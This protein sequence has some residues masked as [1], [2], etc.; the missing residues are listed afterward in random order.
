[1]NRDLLDD[2]VHC[3]FCLDT[4]PTYVLWGEEPDSPRG[5]ILLMDLVEK[6][7]LAMDEAVIRHWDRCLGCMACVTSCPSGV[8]YDRLIEEARAVVGAT[9]RRHRLLFAA[10]PHHR[11]LRPA[12][13][14]IAAYR[15][16]H[17]PR[18]R[19]MPPVSFAG[20]RQRTPPFLPAQGP[21]RLKVAML[22]GCVQRAFFGDV[23]AATAR[24]LSAYGCD[25][26]AP[27]GQGCC[28]ALELHSGQPGAE[29]RRTRLL[30]TLGAVDADVIVVNAAGCGSAL[31]E[32]DHPAAARVRDVHEVLA[33][34]GP[35]AAIRPL[36]MT[37]AY[38]DAC[39]LAHAQ[40]VRA[41]PRAVL[42]HIPGLRVA[43][44][45]DPAI[46][47]GSAGI[48]NLVQR[49]AAAELG[50]RKAASV[51]AVRPDALAAANPGC[52]IQIAAYLDIPTYHPVEL[53]DRA[54]T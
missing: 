47:C 10:L 17:L 14:A 12:A 36:D 15:A 42:R 28:G 13:Y 49:E 33:E 32:A 18:P 8:R 19:L 51:Q 41:E 37:V 2:C 3:G 25:V 54:L 31:K 23:N 48:Y 43:E 50:R 6:G 9:R 34:L 22:L 39:H 27:P 26:I 52:L 20:L 21:A 29:E 35:P 38:H 44:I 30:D 53:L 7:E 11:R 46:C 4:C 16:S 24:V 1:M 5:R 40:G 45:A